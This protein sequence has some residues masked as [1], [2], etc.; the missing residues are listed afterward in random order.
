V[1]LATVAIH[2]LTDFSL[3]I[4]SCVAL[5]VVLGALVSGLGGGGA[6]DGPGPGA[7]GGSGDGDRASLRLGGLG[8][9]LGAGL[10]LATG[11]VIAHEGWRAY[12]VREIQGRASELDRS[13]DP[14]RLDRK[15]ALLEEAARLV[16]EDSLL[17]EDLVSA[18]LNA[19]DQQLYELTEGEAVDAAP[20]AGPGGPRRRPVDAEL[21]R[22]K[23]EHLA[24]A[25]RHLRRSRDLCPLRALVHLEIAEHVG[26]FEAAE[27]RAAYLDRAKLLAPADP[28][29]WYRCGVFELADGQPDRAWAS[30]RHSLELSG[31]FLPKILDQAARHLG[32]RDILGR[33][34]P[35]DPDRLLEAST[36]LS[37][38]SV[39]GRRTFLEGALT[40]L[41]RR[42][43]RLSAE[44]QYLRATIDRSL[45]RAEEA[46]A[47]Y[48]SALAREPLRHDWRYELAEL[49]SEQG[50]LQDSRQELLTI[51]GL[52]PGDARARALLD[53]VTRKI[54][55]GR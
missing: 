40:L 29:L 32:P 55:E 6:D 16:P 39:E 22:L 35:D 48:R 4:P 1:G 14:A 42:P 15:A 25:L 10:A 23:R 7:S 24:P 46:L 54:A 41:D 3:H 34:L 13:G 53:E 19:Y 28:D 8:P 36:H 33:V 21:G 2:S 44:D 47:A 52:R 45:G 51:L 37:P 11:L 50:R 27:P 43:D 18:H 9:P 17:R 30:W 5:V 26:D 31:Q 38:G 20:P 12:R 49:S